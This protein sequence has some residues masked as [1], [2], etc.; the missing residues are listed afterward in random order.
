MSRS[1]CSRHADV[2]VGQRD[3]G[4]FVGLYGERQAYQLRLLRIDAGGFGVEGEQLGVVEFFQPDVE[5]R[6]IEDGFVLRLQT[7]AAGASASAA[8]NRSAAGSGSAA[9][10]Q[11]KAFGVPIKIVQPALEFQQGIQLV[12][13]GRIFRRPFAGHRGRCPAA[14]RP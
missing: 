5:T 14:R 9:A 3:V 4:R 7:S 1:S 2:G 6:L 11:F 8:L 10:A 12:E 13:F